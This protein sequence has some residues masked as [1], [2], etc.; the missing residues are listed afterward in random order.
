MNK[1]LIWLRSL[2]EFEKPQARRPASMSRR[3]FL[4]GLG[5]TAVTVAGGGLLVK[6]GVNPLQLLDWGTYHDGIPQ[7]DIVAYVRKQREM[8][9]RAMADTYE[10]MFW[11]P[12]DKAIEALVQETLEKLGPP[13][14]AEIAKDLQDHVTMRELLENPRDAMSRGSRINFNVRESSHEQT[15]ILR[16]PARTTGIR[17]SRSERRTLQRW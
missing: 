6:H 17:L 11:S 16:G 2:T 15:G 4:R 3:T 5:V 8:A 13:K 10:E 12:P 1:F 9:I 14:F 7:F